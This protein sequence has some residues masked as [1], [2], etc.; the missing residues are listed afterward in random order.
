MNLSKNKVI[1]GVI[2]LIAIVSVVNTQ[3]IVKLTSFVTGAPAPASMTSFNNQSQKAQAISFSSK[4]AAAEGQ[5]YKRGDKSDVI[6]QVQKVLTEQG[7]YKSDISGLFGPRT[8][9]AV[10]AFQLANKLPVTG[11]L[12]LQ[13]RDVILGITPRD[14]TFTRVCNQ[15]SA[16]W[17]RVTSP[18]GGEVYQAGQQ[19][20]VTWQSCMI[21]STEQVFIQ[22]AIGPLNGNGSNNFESLPFYTHND[23]SE[24]VTFPSTLFEAPDSW[25][26]GNNFRVK[27]VLNSNQG[28]SD[29]SDNL[30]TIGEGCAEGTII[31]FSSSG[32]PIFC[33]GEGQNINFG[34]SACGME[35]LTPYQNVNLYGAESSTFSTLVKIKNIPGAY[36]NWGSFEGMIGNVEL[37]D[38]DSGTVIAS[39]QQNGQP[40]FWS[41]VS[42]GDPQSP[43]S[44]DRYYVAN[45]QFINPLPQDLSDNIFLHFTENNEGENGPMPNPDQLFMSVNVF[46]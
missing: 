38:I 44:T 9:A 37:I 23:G 35:V 45:L 33:G 18:N 5:V 17:I 2:G 16:P 40:T 4:T 22:L 26:Y 29:F 28:I 1:G 20:N 34:T 30:F 7:L 12:D 14:I 43:Y 15:N 19:I 42:V 27:V 31:G 24:S 3:A 46:Q 11:I 13:T 10:K 36:C 39:M 6:L 41:T 8:E 25:N 32:N 21:P